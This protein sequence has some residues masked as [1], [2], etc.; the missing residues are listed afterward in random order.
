MCELQIIVLVRF[1]HKF[2]LHL[3]KSDQLV[4]EFKSYRIFMF[5]QQA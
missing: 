1:C 4:Y 3:F 2:V 5:D